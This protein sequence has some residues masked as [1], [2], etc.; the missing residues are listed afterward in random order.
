MTYLSNALRR[1]SIIAALVFFLGGSGLGCMVDLILPNTPATV[2][3]ASPFAILC[4]KLVV[5][6]IGLH[7]TSSSGTSNITLMVLSFRANHP[8]LHLRLHERMACWFRLYLYL[9]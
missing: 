3:N 6:I 2:P 5:V 7:E 8:I 9:E 4:T 1:S